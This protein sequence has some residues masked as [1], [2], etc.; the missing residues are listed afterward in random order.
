MTQAQDGGE[1]IRASQQRQDPGRLKGINRNG[2][3]RFK[4]EF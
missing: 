2:K 3:Q 4:T 1:I